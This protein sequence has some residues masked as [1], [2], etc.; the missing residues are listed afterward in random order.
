MKGELHRRLEGALADRYRL[1]REVGQG[2]MATVFLAQD[3]RHERRVAIKLFR[4][5]LSAVLG[6]DRFLNEIKVTAHLQHPHI[7][8]LYD[9]GAADGLLYYVMPFVEG[10]SL[11]QRMAR[12]RQLPIDESVP[13]RP[14]ARAALMPVSVRARPR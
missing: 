6:A 7:L 4:P 10:E 11:R 1:E 2:G 5:E 13:P 8:P 12:E 3:P 9:S 14:V